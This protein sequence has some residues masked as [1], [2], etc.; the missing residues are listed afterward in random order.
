MATT[1]QRLTPI[2]PWGPWELDKDFFSALS[3]WTLDHPETALDR[4]LKNVCDAIDAGKRY[5]DVVPDKPFPARTLILGLA[6]LVELGRVVSGAKLEVR[7]FATEIIGWVGDMK[8]SFASAENGEFTEATWKNMQKMRDVID[9]ICTW[10]VKRLKEGRWSLSNLKIRNEIAEFKRRFNEARELFRD[11][12]FIRISGGIDAI[13]RTLFMVI[14]YIGTMM[15]ML[16]NIRGILTRWVGTEDRRKYL[17]AALNPHTVP[18][19]TYD[20]QG[21]EP[22][23]EGTRVEIL[24]EMRD[25]INNITPG[26]QNFLWLTGD[27]GCGKSAI[28]ATIARRCKDHDELWAQFFINRNNAATTDPNSYFPS[29]ARQLAARSPD[30]ELVIHE[31]LMLRP[32]LVDSISADQAAKLFTDA[33]AAASKINRMSPVV[34]VIDGLDETNKQRLEDTATIFS[35]LFEALPQYSNAKILISSRTD[36]EIHRPFRKML[37]AEYIK[38]IHLDTSAPSSIRDVSNYL[39]KQLDKIAQRHG[40]NATVWP[41]H[42]ID[43]LTS[44][45]CG[46][47]IWAVTVAKFLDAQLTKFGTERLSHV[48]DRLDSKAMRDINNLYGTVL[49]LTYADTDTDDWELETLRRVLG[50]IVVL[51]EPMSLSNLGSLLNLR[52]HPHSDPVDIQNFVRRL[53]TILVAG[54][55]E[56][57]DTTIPRLH[58]SFVEFITGESADRRYRIDPAASN[59]E[60][61]VQCLHHL[62]ETYSG[63][64]AAQFKSTASRSLPVHLLYAVKFHISHLSQLKAGIVIDSG[65]LNVN[66][67]ELHTLLRSSSNAQC[68]GPLRIGRSKD[69]S[70]VLTTLDNRTHVW[71]GAGGHPVVDTPVSAQLTTPDNHTDA[72]DGAG[73][74]PVI[75]TPVSAQFYH[76]R[77]VGCLSISPDGKQ[78]AFGSSDGVIRTLDVQ[79]YNP[80]GSPWTGHTG[81]ATTLCFSPDGKLLAS[82]CFDNTIFIW[83]TT[84]GQPIGTPLIGHGASVSS[85]IFSPD[86]KHIVSASHDGTLRV[87]DARN[88]RPIGPPLHGHRGPVYCVTLSSDGAQILSSSA[89]GTIRRWDFLTG[90][91]IGPP[92]ESG[93]GPV[94]GVA[95]S[96]DSNLIVSGS[97]DR[98]ISLWDART[99]RRIGSPWVGHTS[100]VLSVTFSRSEGHVLSLSCTGNESLRLWDVQTGR[101]I[102]EFTDFGRDTKHSAALTPDGKQV[103]SGGPTGLRIWDIPRTFLDHILQTTFTAFAP[104]GDLVLSGDSDHTVR[105]CSRRSRVMDIPFLPEVAQEGFDHQGAGTALSSVIF[106]PDESRVAGVSSNGTIYLWDSDVDGETG[107]LLGFSPPNSIDST[108]SLSF[109][110]DGL[111]IAVTPINSAERPSVWVAKDGKLVNVPG[112]EVPQPLEIH[113]SMFFDVAQTPHTYAGANN[114]RLR[115]VRCYPR[116]ESDTGTWA[117]VNNHII[118]AGDDGVA[119]VV[120]VSR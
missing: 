47:F 2:A 113:E 41:E 110:S 19:P 57:N 99:G 28:T 87:W 71:D 78:V 75:V 42:R 51:Q 49:D 96:R 102:M 45:A 34:I 101:T 119:I 11:R 38:H 56:I 72:W 35:T 62:T 43:M 89:D 60:V 24:A 81:W 92:L 93:G 61:A 48:L 97:A 37:K 79:T 54:T 17:A 10:A 76:G 120:P 5:S 7:T 30:I 84:T 27:P 25:W 23:D 67:A 14:E 4:V 68:L 53:R 86:S 74:H 83:D 55:D 106:S 22:C 32:S 98:T 33:I 114:S 3:R 8:S 85:V 80:L 20:R 26:S 52:Q 118:R 88:C 21:K 70:Q 91:P 66:L 111:S 39:R 117:F 105:F 64:R 108:E 109:T 15:F 46:L 40:L 31:A 36:D 116:R 29:I 104:S 100:S 44:H 9:E 13:S 12:S 16:Q 73:G 65:D 77:A 6:N 94:S 69:G 112:P 18:D 103:I 59:A 107:S 115:T 58:K 63:I 82:G 95:I 90:Q 1:S 50:A